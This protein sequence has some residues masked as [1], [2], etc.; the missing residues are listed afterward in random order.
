MIS[1]SPG[2]RL[3]QAASDLIGVPFK[4][5]GRDPRNGLDCV[6]L[7]AASLAAIGC[8]VSTP[9]GYRLRNSNPSRWLHFADRSGLSSVTGERLAGDVI[10]LCP[11]PIQQ[12]LIVVCDAELGIH[13]HA[14]LRRVVQQRLNFSDPIL[15]H[16]RLKAAENRRQ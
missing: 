1:P 11:S 10:L 8:S 14:G 4:L 5:H 3:A 15:A 16:W 9:E 13:A 12:H 6:G 7:V 2:E